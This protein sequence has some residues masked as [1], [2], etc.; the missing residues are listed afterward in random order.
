MVDT[1]NLT[2]KISEYLGIATTWI[3]WG[4][5]ILITLGVIGGV[6]LW[7]K[8]RKKWNL[9]VEIKLP[10]SDGKLINSEKAKGYFDTKNGFV[11]L[12][13][14]GLNPIDMKPFNVNKYLQGTNYLEVIQIGPDDF[15]PVLPKSYTIIYKS[16]AI[17]GEQ[18]KFGLLEIYGDLGERKQWASNA[19]ESALNRFTLKSFLKR[20][21]FAISI[22]IIMFGLFIG[23]AI[24]LSQLPK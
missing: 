3:I 22:M 10:R 16:D 11:S 9:R 15:I 12:K 7:A 23:F 21:E 13:R 5:V 18:N 2:G 20:H 4:F 19:A 8:K 17:E 14:K 24:V 1:I 6:A